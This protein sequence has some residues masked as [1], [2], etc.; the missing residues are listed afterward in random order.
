MKLT[1]EQVEHWRW[2][3]G[4]A[5]D[6]VWV[7]G[8]LPPHGDDALQAL[9]AWADAGIT[10]IL[11]VRGEWSDEHF[12]AEHA[13]QMGYTHVGTDDDGNGQSDQWFDAGVAAAREAL[14]DDGAGL[15]VHCHMGINRGP[16]MAL[17][18]LLDRG[19]RTIDAL[20]AIR[21][22][23]PIA[24][25]AYAEDAVRW[26]SRRNGATR[27]DIAREQALVRRWHQ[28]HEIDVGRVIRKIRRI[29]TGPVAS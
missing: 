2:A 26:H 21:A 27:I 19:W 16:S 23:R 3:I 17:A 24:A 20:D 14:L 11:D 4:E 10:D 29:E 25:I 22:A 12:V 8:D 7:G 28:D 1:T 18:I 13:G 15:L 5:G 6:G 9:V